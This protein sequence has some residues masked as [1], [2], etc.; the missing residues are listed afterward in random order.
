MAT[1][2]SEQNKIENKTLELL[3]SKQKKK[4]ETLKSSENKLNKNPTR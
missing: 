2:R 3:H 1:E 4:K